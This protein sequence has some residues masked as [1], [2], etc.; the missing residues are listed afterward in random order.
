MSL[1]SVV[2]L[3]PIAETDAAV[4][5]DL[6]VQALEYQGWISLWSCSGICGW[7]NQP[8]ILPVWRHGQRCV[9]NGKQQHCQQNT[10]HQQCS[11]ADLCTCSRAR[12]AACPQTYAADQGQGRHEDI[13]A[14]AIP[15]ESATGT[16]MQL[17][18]A[19]PPSCLTFMCLSAGPS[20]PL[21]A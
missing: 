13:L 8:S 7:N 17:Q 14:R 9:K 12:A 1:R 10:H 5:I 16:N 3:A 20:C 21:R 11:R 18:L 15:G 2:Q 6:C 4:D 19:T